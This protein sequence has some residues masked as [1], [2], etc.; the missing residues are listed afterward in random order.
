MNLSTYF[1]ELHGCAVGI[2]G[3]LVL[4]LMLLWRLMVQMEPY[5]GRWNAPI[6]T[7]SAFV[8]LAWNFEVWICYVEEGWQPF[9]IRNWF[10]TYDDKIW[11]H[12]WYWKIRVTAKAADCFKLLSQCDF[13]RDFWHRTSIFFFSPCDSSSFKKIYLHFGLFFPH[14]CLHCIHFLVVPAF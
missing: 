2:N 8:L 9:F 4:T 14:S 10:I 13:L 6:P 12:S 3:S 5:I 7:S 1:K 11:W